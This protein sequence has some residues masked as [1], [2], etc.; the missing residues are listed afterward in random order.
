MTK[1]TKTS[2]ITVPDYNFEWKT[3]D[4]VLAHLHER[5]HFPGWGCITLAEKFGTDE[6]TYRKAEI[7]WQRLKA[8]FNK[9]AKHYDPETNYSRLGSVGEVKEREVLRSSWWETINGDEIGDYELTYLVEALH[10]GEKLE[11]GIIHFGS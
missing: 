9:E 10:Y 3:V 8:A 1:K 2:T 11:T 5:R 6:D 4:E 7:I